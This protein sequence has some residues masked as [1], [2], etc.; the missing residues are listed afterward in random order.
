MKH[1]ILAKFRPEIA[2]KASLMEPIRAL[3]SEAADIPGVRGADVYPCCID[4]ENRYDI[5]I[6]LDMDR[7]ALPL[8]DVSQMHHAWK[9]QYGGLLEKK[10]IFDCEM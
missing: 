10:A 9:E 5:M 8:Y 3:F 7:D 4:R 1:F 2:D 6:V